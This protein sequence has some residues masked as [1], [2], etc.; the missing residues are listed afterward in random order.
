MSGVD[1]LPLAFLY[2]D[3]QRPIEGITRFQKL[4]FLAQKETNLAEEYEFEADKFGPFSQELYSSID[5]LEERGLVVKKEQ[6]TPSGNTKYIYSLSDDGHR[7]V[8]EVLDREEYEHLTD[9]FDEADS[10]KSEHN[11]Q[12]LG[13]L[14]EYVYTRYPKYTV[15]SE[16]D[17]GP[18]G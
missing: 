1:V 4:V 13:E 8:K 18:A 2:T 11:D 10:I 15:E 7:L 16:L 9:V 17:I 5:E 12:L 6:Q 3:G 14:L